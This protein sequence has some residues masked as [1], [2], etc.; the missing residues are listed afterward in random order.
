MILDQ[1]KTAEALPWKELIDCLDKI[2]T[3][4]VNSPVRHHHNMKVPGDPDA[5]LLLMPAWIEGEYSG[6]KI[7]NVFPGNNKR[8]LA[9]LTGH[10]LLSCG[11]TGRLFLQ[12]DGNEL[13]S[14]RTAAVSAL[15]SR[16]LSRE[17]TN[18]M[19]MVGT[20][21][22]ARYLIPAHMSVRPIEVVHVWGRNPDSAQ[23]LVEELRVDGINAHICLPE[24]LQKVAQQV[25][26]ISCATMA[27]EPLIMG[28]WLSAG[29]HLDLVGSFTPKM[30]ET[31][32]A[33]MQIGAVFVDTRAGAFS[34]TG[35]ILIPISEGAITE[36]SIVAEFFD[37]CSGQHR[38]RA[39]LVNSDKAITVFKSVGAAIEDLA[40][41]I[42]AKSRI[43]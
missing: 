17:D 37:L 35:D 32:N 1:Q 8:G 38:G 26:L 25:D 12:L 4:T 13:T 5:T 40:A 18:S 2:F 15:A 23:H 10:Y 7:V 19:L 34:E 29:A 11:K 30:R 3:Q 36:E 27:T 39:D 21:R 41:A 24:N 31:N 6:V 9:G 14:R 16:Y 20:G 33:A 43:N 28:E 42:L 22:M